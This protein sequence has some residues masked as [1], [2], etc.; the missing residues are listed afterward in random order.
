[1][2]SIKF[3]PFG[4]IWWNDFVLRFAG[5]VGPKSLLTCYLGFGQKQIMTTQPD[6]EYHP[7]ETKFRART[8]RRLAEDPSLP[9]TALP[10]GYPQKV[11][12]P[13]VW[14]GKDWQNEDQWV[15]NLTPLELQEIGDA[16]AHF[17]GRDY[18]IP[19]QRRE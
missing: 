13:I 17:K 19:Y 3:S 10:T 15:Y 14:E 5:D 8:A 1:L 11:E 12:G 2:T 16:L 6:I 4:Y 9:S 7:D 18:R